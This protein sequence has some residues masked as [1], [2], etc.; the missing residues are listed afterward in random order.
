MATTAKASKA[1]APKKKTSTAKAP[2]KETPSYEF[3]LTAPEAATVYLVGDFNHW[4]EGKDKM[5]KTKDGSHKKSIKLKPG[6]YEYRFV[7][8]GHWWT[9]P[10]NDNRCSSPFGSDN[11]VLVIPE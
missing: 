11:S 1:T 10:L 3:C 4:A 6:R 8:D 9:D 7:V 2:K 5:R